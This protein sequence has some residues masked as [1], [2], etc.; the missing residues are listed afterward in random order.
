MVVKCQLLRRFLVR[1]AR[2]LGLEVIDRCNLT[3]LLEPG[4]EDLVEFLASHQARPQSHCECNL[5]AVTELEPGQEGLVHFLA[6]Y[7]AHLLAH[8]VSGSTEV[9]LRPNHPAEPPLAFAY[10]S[11]PEPAWRSARSPGLP[12]VLAV[13]SS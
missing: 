10:C 12:D 1:E 4:Q 9:P 2:A 3:V 5:H 8:L 13:P 11:H 7:W 6:L